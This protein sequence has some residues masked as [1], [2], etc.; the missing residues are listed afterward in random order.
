MAGRDYPYSG[1]DPAVARTLSTNYA[2]RVGPVVVFLSIGRCGTQWLAATFAELY[3][4]SVEVEHEPLGGRYWP[5]RFFRSYANPEAI[6]EL[7]E[8]AAHVARVARSECYVET[9]WPVLA[10]LP[11]LA[12]RFRD[13]L[14]VVHLTQHLEPAHWWYGQAAGRSTSAV[15]P[16]AVR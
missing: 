11:L 2:D 12:A 15:K 5:R 14:R 8:V 16:T 13:R 1:R 10:A 6:L 9:G 3:G 4:E 7:P